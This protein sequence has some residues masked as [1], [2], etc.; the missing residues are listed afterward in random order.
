M[1]LADEDIL[2]LRH[3]PSRIHHM[4]KRI[5]IKLLDRRGGRWL[6]GWIASAYATAKLR[7][8]YRVV[9]SESVWVYRCMGETWVTPNLTVPAAANATRIRERIRLL[10]SITAGCE[11]SGFMRGA[12]VVDVGAGIGSMIHEASRLVGPSGRIIA[13]EA[14]PRTLLCLRKMCRYNA[15]DNIVF[16]P[17]AG[18]RY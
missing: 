17:Y 9:A 7:M 1:L 12:T 11:G 8:V 13:I 15:F 4:M 3:S 16:E 2:T 5:L 6:L 14:H 10:Q 18:L